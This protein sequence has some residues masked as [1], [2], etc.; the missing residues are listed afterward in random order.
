VILPKHKKYEPAGKKAG[1]RTSTIMIEQADACELYE[2]EEVTL[3][4]WG[5]AYMKVNRLTQ[6]CKLHL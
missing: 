4:D 2:G 5:N 1:V 6:S 3:M